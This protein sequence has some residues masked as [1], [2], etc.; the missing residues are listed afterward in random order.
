MVLPRRNHSRP[1]RRR[2]LACT[3]AAFLLVIVYLSFSNW[4][5][6]FS[7]SSNFRWETTSSSSPSSTPRSHGDAATG[8]NNGQAGDLPLADLLSGNPPY[9][10]DRRRNFQ[11]EYDEVIAGVPGL[12]GT[13]PARFAF[14]IMAHG[15][16]DV[17][18][19][20]RNLPWLYSPLNFFLVRRGDIFA[21]FLHTRRLLSVFLSRGQS[22][23]ILTCHPGGC[24][25]RARFTGWVWDTFVAVFVCV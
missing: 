5:P 4:H 16:T 15:P 10:R 3:T 6:F 9:W 13:K 8:G 20:K 21:L 1:T 11:A 14:L 17:M 2:H 7:S 24:S 19:L 23:Y 22:R 12:R 18:L 25:H